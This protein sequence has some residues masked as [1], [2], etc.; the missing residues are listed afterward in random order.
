MSAMPNIF[1]NDGL[2]ES[3]QESLGAI[4][5]QT[6]VA[7][8]YQGSP[9]LDPSWN[10]SNFTLATFSGYSGSQLVTSWGSVVFVAPR[11]QSIGALLQWTHDGGPTPNT[12][13]GAVIYNPDT[14][15]VRFAIERPTPLLVNML[16]QAVPLLPIYTRRSEF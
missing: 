4:P 12:I 9:T 5:L 15:A 2:V 14:S 11:A 13:G 3:L 1:F 7:D 8:L 6:L 16:G 10:V